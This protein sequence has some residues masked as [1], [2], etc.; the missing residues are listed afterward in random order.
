MEKKQCSH[1]TKREIIN[2]LY[3]DNPENTSYVAQVD[4]D[5]NQKNNVFLFN[6]TEEKKTTNSNISNSEKNDILHNDKSNNKSN[7]IK[8]QVSFNE[9]PIEIPVNVSKDE[10]KLTEIVVEN[11]K[12]V[13]SD[14]LSS[15]DL[16]IET[17]KDVPKDSPSEVTTNVEQ[18]E[19]NVFDINKKE[20]LI[21]ENNLNNI[22]T[23]MINSSRDPFSK[24]TIEEI[25]LN[26]KT[27]GRIKEHDKMYLRDN[28]FLEIDDSYLQSISRTIKSS[29]WNGYNR[30]DIIDFLIHLT[31]ETMKTCASLVQ[32][33]TMNYDEN[34]NLILKS[35]LLGMEIAVNGLQKLKITYYNDNTILTRLDMIIDDNFNKKIREVRDFVLHNLKN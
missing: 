9:Q 11:K 28:K 6:R 13:S 22:T 29:L 17:S 14:N 19:N 27:L 12:D 35:L 3:Y 16:P 23:L 5:K 8:K 2:N 24:L 30:E 34:N 15:G 21:V 10:P 31:N 20:E 7:E 4:Y 1:K 33:L 25:A 32:L 18:T 26:F